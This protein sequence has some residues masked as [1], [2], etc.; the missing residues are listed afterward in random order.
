MNPLPVVGGRAGFDNFTAEGNDVA[1]LCDARA[2]FVVVGEMVDECG[3]SADAV[4]GLAA[5]GE[6]G[7]KAVADA[8][9]KPFR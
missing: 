7:A 4:E 6:R 9:F 2:K 8:A 5:H 3:E 1:G